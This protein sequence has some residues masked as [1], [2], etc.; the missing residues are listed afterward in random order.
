MR[1]LVLSYIYAPDQ[2][3][4]AYRWS[5]IA[6]HW[7]AAG[8]HVEIVAGWKS[9]DVRREDRNGVVVHRV[10]GGI[11]ERLR[12]F[13]GAGSHRHQPLSAA[14][15]AD[16]TAPARA[17]LLMRLAKAVYRGTIRQVL[18][19]D[20]AYHWFPTA[21]AK[22]TALCGAQPFDALV[23]VSHPFTAHLVGLAIKRRRPELRW[24]V[25]IG[26]PF[27]LLDEIPLNNS[28][29]LSPAQPPRRGARA[30]RGRCR[31]GHR[32]ALPHRL[33]RGVPRI[34]G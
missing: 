30:A 26:D 3:P 7:A 18:W 28:A 31:R 4:R 2:S 9:G 12:G 15:S 6:E 5:A 32:R 24:L 34:A 8:H 27:S 19:P 1:I 33:P 11:V 14:A 21:L 25:D 22:A 10:G 29:P 13:L 20:Y 17:S 23:S 16:K